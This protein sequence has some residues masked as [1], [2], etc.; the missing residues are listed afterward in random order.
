MSQIWSFQSTSNWKQGKKMLILIQYSKMKLTV[1]FLS[2]LKFEISQ[3]E[4]SFTQKEANNM[5]FSYS[6]Q[7]QTFVNSRN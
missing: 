2:L 3:V 1:S 7:E 4:I 6:F 5:Q